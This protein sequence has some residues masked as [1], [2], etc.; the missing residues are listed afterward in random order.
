MPGQNDRRNLG[1]LCNRTFATEA[2]YR[3][4]QQRCNEELFKQLEAE[5]AAS[6]TE[7]HT[8]AASNGQTR[9]HANGQKNG[10]KHGRLG[11]GSAPRSGS[12]RVFAPSAAPPGLPQSGAPRPPEPPPAMKQF[13][14]LTGAQLNSSQ[15][16]TRYLIPGL[17]AA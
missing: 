14:L 11:G 1:K 8:R 12:P 17:L 16:E 2:E 4:E 5:S 13:R 9:G 7:D 10:H 15:F 3:Q 6:L